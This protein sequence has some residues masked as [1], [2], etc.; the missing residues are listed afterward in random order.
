MK[1]FE[2]SFCGGS[3]KSYKT[4]LKPKLKALKQQ[5]AKSKQK[6]HHTGLELNTDKGLTMSLEEIN[7]EEI[8]FLT[9]SLAEN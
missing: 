5:T 3:C 8:L 6:P 7:Q 1:H 4:V 9:Q 2:G